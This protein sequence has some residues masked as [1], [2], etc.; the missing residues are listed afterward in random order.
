[1]NTNNRIEMAPKTEKTEKICRNL[2]NDSQMSF[3]MT[4]NQQ[5]I[6]PATI[7]QPKSQ[8]SQT[9]DLSDDGLIKNAINNE[10]TSSKI[11]VTS[12]INS[13]PIISN[14]CKLFTFEFAFRALK[15]DKIYVIYFSKQYS[16]TICSK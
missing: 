16:G 1:M 13:L 11:F 4:S 8:L 9:C 10:A 7:T 14:K 12:Q 6:I 5:T 15:I 2:M 3:L